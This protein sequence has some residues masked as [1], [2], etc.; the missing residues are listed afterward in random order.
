MADNDFGPLIWEIEAGQRPEWR[1]VSDR[2][3]IYE[4]L[5]PVKS[6]AL[7][8]GVLEPHWDSTDGKK[9]AQRIIPHSKL[10][11]ILPEMHGGTSGELTKS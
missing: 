6:L 4:L 8:D 3:P 1:D 2:G 7:R 10:K 9:R 5:V 11:E